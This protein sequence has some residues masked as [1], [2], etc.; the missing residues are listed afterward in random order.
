MRLVIGLAVLLGQVVE[1]YEEGAS[2][3]IV[4]IVLSVQALLLFFYLGRRKEFVTAYVV[5][6]G[7][8]LL[9]FGGVAV[10]SDSA[11]LLGGFAGL[12]IGESPFMA[13]ILFS[14]RVRNT[15][16]RGE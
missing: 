13:Y 4:L 5:A 12:V 9:F 7:A 6:N 14:K 3:Y 8:M 10:L 11:E 15:F 16:V 2:Q 1:L